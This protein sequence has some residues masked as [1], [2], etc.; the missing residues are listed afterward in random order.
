MNIS[1]NSI[2]KIIPA[3]IGRFHMVIFVVL[4]FG[5][6]AVAVMILNNIIQSSTSTAIP[7]TAAE[8]SASFDQDTI[9]R[10]EKLKT[11]TELNNDLVL[12][13]GRINPFVE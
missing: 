1:S 3:I 2:K 4:V 7:Q 13:P 10:I 5:G 6:L 9:K 11:S 8:L 12:P